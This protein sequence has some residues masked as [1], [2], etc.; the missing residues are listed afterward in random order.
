MPYR[1]FTTSL[2]KIGTRRVSKGTF[3]VE[4]VIV[5]SIITLMLLATMQI[6]ALSTRI[7]RRA[8][9]ETQVAFL[10]EEGADVV[11]LIRDAGWNSFSALTTGTPYYLVHGVGG[12]TLTTSPTLVD[13]MFTRSVVFSTV[14]RDGND[15]IVTSGGT[16]DSGTR[17][18]TVTISW[19]DGSEIVTKALTF[20]LTDI[21][22]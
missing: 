4:V 15:D 21:I 19:N 3:L 9:A 8:L 11:R 5:V 1:S 20:Y 12:W 17:K 10:A 13:S 16:L 2:E 14:N 22:S 6:T 18:V 7:S